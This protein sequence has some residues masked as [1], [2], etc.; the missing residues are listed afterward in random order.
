MPTKRKQRP[1]YDEDVEILKRKIKDI[2][3]KDGRFEKVVDFLI[4]VID[5]NE[6]EEVFFPK[7]G[8]FL[9]KKASLKVRVDAT[10]YLFQGT[11]DRIIGVVRELPDATIP[12]DPTEELKAIAKKKREEAAAKKAKRGKKVLYL[13][14]KQE[15]DQ[16]VT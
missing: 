1:A 7:T 4:S 6:V 2:L 3:V 10:K 16:S 9:Q 15:E 5:G 13:N 12:F 14:E 11:L 8:S